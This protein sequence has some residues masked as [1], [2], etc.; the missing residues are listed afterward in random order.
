M[1]ARLAQHAPH[2]SKACVDP[3]SAHLT[4]GVM[5]LPGEG[6][7]ARATEL[8]AALAAPLAQAALLQP[9][10]VQ[11]EGLSHFRNQVRGARGTQCWDTGTPPLCLSISGLRLRGQEVMAGWGTAGVLHWA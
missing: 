10:E 3:A 9:V 4:L 7:R 1:H 2:L 5:A 8:L 11:L 6:D